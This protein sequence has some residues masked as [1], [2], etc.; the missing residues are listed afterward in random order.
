MPLQ[1]WRLPGTESAEPAHMQSGS[2]RHCQYRLTRILQLAQKLHA[3]DRAGCTE[4]EHNLAS[5]KPLNLSANKLHTGYTPVPLKTHTSKDQTAVGNQMLCSVQ[6]RIE[7][8]D[9]L[10]GLVSVCK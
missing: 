1:M 10:D 6:L 3:S 9:I 2:G 8:G 5:T 7:T 4:P